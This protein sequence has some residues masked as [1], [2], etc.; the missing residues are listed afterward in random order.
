MMFRTIFLSV[1]ILLLAVAG[2]AFAEYRD[3]LDTP[4]VQSPLAARGLLNGVVLAGDRLVAVGQRGHIVLSQ[5]RGKTW[6]QARVPVSSDLVAVNFPT[7]DQG[8]AVGHDGVVLHSEDGGTTW[9]KVFDGILAARTMADYYAAHPPQG[10]PAEGEEADNFQADLQWFVDLG[11]DKP[12]LDVWFE[13]A[14]T[15]YIVGAFNLLFRTE[16]GGKSWIPWFDRIDNPSR[17]HLYAI[18]PV[19]SDLYICGEQ[20]SIFRLDPQQGRFVAFEPP[21]DGTFFGIIGKPGAVVAFGMRGTIFRSTDNGVSWTKIA[22][23][24]QAGLTGATLTPDGRILL[25]SQA[26]QVLVSADDGAS[27][28]LLP[29]DRPF[30]AGAIT[31]LDGE[32][33][34]LAGLRGTKVGTL[35]P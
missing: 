18:R 26:G 17:L 22:S 21:Y 8:W 33:L 28:S 13:N 30:P 4:A 6:S 34:V 20:G 31:A 24:V 19:G 2:G 23:G 32:T 3:V 25:V 29:T 16:D 15:G 12:F 27:F 11:A 7:A 5:D 35:Q 1:F 14:T 10:V 9:N